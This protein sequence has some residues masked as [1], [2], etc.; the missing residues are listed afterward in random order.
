[1]LLTIPIDDNYLNCKQAHARGWTTAYLLEP[2][3][4]E[5]VEKAS[6]HQIREM[7]ELRTIWPQFFKKGSTADN[8]KRS[9]L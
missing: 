9:Q 8:A 4:P 7:E 3:A 2:G 1:M 5:V 6:D